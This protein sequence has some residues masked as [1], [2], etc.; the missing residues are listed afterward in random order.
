MKVWEYFG[1][2]E[3]RGEEIVSEI[4]AI[5]KNKTFLE[6]L[7]FVNENYKKSNENRFAIWYCGFLQAIL[8]FVSPI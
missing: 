6:M 3:K 1:L 5:S 4:D 8:V 7:E 2:V